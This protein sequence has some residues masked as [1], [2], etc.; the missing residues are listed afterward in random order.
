MATLHVRNVP[1]D[2][3]E[4]LR[5]RA[6][7]RGRSISEESIELLRD[8]LRPHRAAVLDVLEDLRARP[9]RVAPGMPKPAEII[10]ADRD[11]R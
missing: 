7:K 2:L 8:A 4:A 6:S 5:R 1:D 10:R 9:L 3:Y 11:A